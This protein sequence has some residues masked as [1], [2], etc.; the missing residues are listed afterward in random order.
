MEWRRICLC[1]ER[2]QMWLISTFVYLLILH[3][4]NNSHKR[5]NSSNV[6]TAQKGLNKKKRWKHKDNSVWNYLKKSVDVTNA[7]EP[8]YLAVV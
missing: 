6:T 7:N 5:Y 3:V 2:L 8:L 1:F 4:F